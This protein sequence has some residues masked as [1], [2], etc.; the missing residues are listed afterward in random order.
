MNP[1]V[2]FKKME[3]ARLSLWR[4]AI[5]LSIAVDICF[6]VSWLPALFWF[7]V[8]IYW[9]IKIAGCTVV[10]CFSLK[11]LKSPLIK[12]MIFN[13][14]SPST[15]VKT[16]TS[17][18]IRLYSAGVK[19]MGSPVMAIS[20][21]GRKRKRIVGLIVSFAASLITTEESKESWIPTIFDLSVVWPE[22]IDA[23]VSFL[24]D[25]SVA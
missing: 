11:S 4:M 19:S 1:V 14:W 10:G 23:S 24:F 3:A 20:A 5:F 7:W 17:A 9:V 12:L 15:I 8:F 22:L 16:L 18:A 13:Y 21:F 6:C 25:A 2:T